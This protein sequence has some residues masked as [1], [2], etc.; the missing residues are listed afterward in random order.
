MSNYALPSLPY[1]YD[2]LEPHLASELL[3]FTPRVSLIAGL[4][5][6][7]RSIA[8][9]EQPERALASAGLDE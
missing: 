9:E 5:E 3:D 8:E 4:A 1:R 2:A 6:V 7:V